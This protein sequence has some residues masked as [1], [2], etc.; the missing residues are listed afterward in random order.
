MDVTPSVQR[1]SIDKA[2]YSCII[3]TKVLRD[4][5]QLPCCGKR[6]CKTCITLRCPTCDLPTDGE[7][8]SGSMK[9]SLGS[10]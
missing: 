2:K 8:V 5:M 3:C 6:V 4:P 1:S 7:E 9:F 10:F